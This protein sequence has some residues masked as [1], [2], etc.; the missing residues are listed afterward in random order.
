[1]TTRYFIE[2]DFDSTQLAKQARDDFAQTLTAQGLNC[3][4]L[5]LLRATDNITIDAVEATQPEP[6]I[7]TTKPRNTRDRSLKKRDRTPLAKVEIR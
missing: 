2:S 1:M 5:T 6:D 3:R 4:S 7:E